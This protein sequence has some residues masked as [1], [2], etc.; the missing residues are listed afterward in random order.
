M[1]QHPDLNGLEQAMKPIDFSSGSTSDHLPDSYLKV[2][3]VT[4]PPKHVEFLPVVQ[5]LLPDTTEEG[6]AIQQEN[7]WLQHVQKYCDDVPTKDLSPSWA[8]F[9]ANGP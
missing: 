8:A 6:S 4:K 2:H 3:P 1:I 7:E 9:H 5:P